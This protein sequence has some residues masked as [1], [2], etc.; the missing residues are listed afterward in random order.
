MGMTAML[1]TWGQTLVRHVHLHCLVPG[2]A[3][4][5]DGTWHPAK[6]TYLF[7]VRTLSRHLRGG[8]VNRLLAAFEAGRLQRIT[9]RNAVDRVLQTLMSKDWVVYSKPCLAR[10][11]TVVDYLGRYT[12]RTAVSDGRLLGFGARRQFKQPHRLRTLRINQLG[13]SEA[14]SLSG[15]WN[16]PRLRAGGVMAAIASSLSV[17]SARR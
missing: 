3:L 4:A 17:G 8:F 13:W 14:I 16:R 6:S 5:D 7:P 10:A 2:G 11:E 1:H 15:I 12:H 9:D